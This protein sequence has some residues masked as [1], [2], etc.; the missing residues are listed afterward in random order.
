MQP[1]LYEHLS[2][3]MRQTGDWT[4][5][6]LVPVTPDMLTPG[7]LRASLVA[8]LLE[9]SFG[10]NLLAHGFP[11][12]SQMTF[13]LSDG[14][15]GVDRLRAEGELVQLGK[16]RASGRG[17]VVDADNPDRLIGYG[18]I[19]FTMIRP[20]GDYMPG[21]LKESLE[22]DSEAYPDVSE[23]P[24]LE[25]MGMH[26]PP[27]EPVCELGG[28]IHPGVLGPEGRLHGGAHQLM[29]ET[30]AIAAA[31]LES[32]SERVLATEQSIQFIAPAFEGP[33]IAS[34]SILS[35]SD[36]DLLCLV[37]LRDSRGDAPRSM[38]TF[39]LRVLS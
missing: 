20:E 28:S 39:R 14:G 9:G 21:D 1:H 16:R 34:A 22:A 6:G 7:G 17:R 8:L 32:G 13:H 4:T 30:A 33:F 29:H 2:M 12:L 23:K 27:G 36:E 38:S 31:T 24:L 15:A 37:E 3:D 35:A 11:V 18:T 26:V 25:A 10:D 5:E 19:G